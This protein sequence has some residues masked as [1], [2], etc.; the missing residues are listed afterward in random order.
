MPVSLEK[1]KKWS[2]REALSLQ[3]PSTIFLS[4]LPK[5]PL[6]LLEGWDCRSEVEDEAPQVCLL[7]VSPEAIEELCCDIVWDTGFIFFSIARSLWQSRNALVLTHFSSIPSSG[8]MCTAVFCW[9]IKSNCR[10]HRVHLHWY[11]ELTLKIFPA[12][13][14]QI[15]FPLA[16]SRLSDSF[17]GWPQEL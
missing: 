13:Q 9:I 14:I 17:C 8:H 15:Y 4:A 11:L 1:H 7:Q 3:N 10:S 5:L 6:S 2:V 16:L 12:S